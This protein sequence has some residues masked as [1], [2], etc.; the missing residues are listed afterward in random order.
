MFLHK[1]DLRTILQFMESFDYAN[2]HAMVEITCDNSSGIGSVIQ[3]K[4]HGVYLNGQQVSVT[5]TIVDEK[6]W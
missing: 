2:E 1:D 5:K 4:I 6:D 3:A